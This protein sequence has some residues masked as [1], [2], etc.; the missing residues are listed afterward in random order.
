MASVEIPEGFDPPLVDD[1]E[2][3][4]VKHGFSRPL[5][6]LGQNEAIFW[7]RVL[8]DD[9][10]F[11][12]LVLEDVKNP[13]AHEVE[14]LGLKVR[15]DKKFIQLWSLLDQVNQTSLVLPGPGPVLPPWSGV[16]FVGTW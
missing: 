5:G 3:V 2:A 6:V 14:L 8:E 10:I 9:S 12:F 13:L 4:H 16:S 15:Q 7:V 11:I 1:G